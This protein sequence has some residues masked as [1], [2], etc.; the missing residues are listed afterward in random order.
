MRLKLLVILTAI[1]LI[2]TACSCEASFTTA[3][4]KD[5]SM[6][7]MGE[8][9][10][11]LTDV[12]ETDTPEIF[13]LGVLDNAPGTTKIKGEWYYLGEEEIF[14]DSAEMEVED[15]K[16][17]FYFNLSIPDDGWPVG[18]YEVRLYIDDEFQ[19]SVEFEVK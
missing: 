7:K 1:V 4:Y 8:D 9:D 13:V 18:S 17:D 12:F 5:L 6:A 16:T 10:F 15:I 3:N 19:T 14:I 11:T 2:I